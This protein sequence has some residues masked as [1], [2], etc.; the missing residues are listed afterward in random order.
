[1][2][3]FNNIISKG[4]GLF[5]QAMTTVSGVVGGVTGMVT[6]VVNGTMNSSGL[7]G[8][9]T[10][11]DLGN[12]VGGVTS[13]FTGIP[14]LGGGSGSDP[15][16]SNLWDTNNTVNDDS[17]SSKNMIIAG[18]ALVIGLIIALVYAFKKK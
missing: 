7:T 2:G 4:S 1:M 12:I 6:N 10:H 8:L 16:K 13:A 9:T 14:S 15:N 11:P 17:K 3:L 5:G 18:V